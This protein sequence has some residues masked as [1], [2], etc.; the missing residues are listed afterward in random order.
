MRATF[1]RKALGI[2]PGSVLTPEAT[3]AGDKAG[4][5]LRQHGVHLWQAG[6]LD[7]VTQLHGLSQLDEGNVIAGIQSRGEEW[8]EGP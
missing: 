5:V 3:P 6:H 8:A 7:G 2:S 4:V 1:S